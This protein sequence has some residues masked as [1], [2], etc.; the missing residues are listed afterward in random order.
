MGDQAGMQMIIVAVAALA[1]DPAPRGAFVRGEWGR[2]RIGEYRVFYLVREDL[3]IVDRVDRVSLP[4][5][6]AD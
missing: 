4:S 2:L 6:E 3:I 5:P 1:D